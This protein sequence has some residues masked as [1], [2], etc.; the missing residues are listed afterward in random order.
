[1]KLPFTRVPFDGKTA[2]LMTAFAGIVVMGAAVVMGPV[3]NRFSELEGS[4]V[5]SE[6]RMASNLRLSASKDVVESEYR[7]YGGYIAKKGTTSEENAAMLA[8][9]E[10]LAGDCKIVLT[11]T[12]PQES[13]IEPDFEEY[14]ADLEIESDLEQMIRFFFA[15]ESSRQFLRVERLTVDSKGGRE[16]GTL[17]GTL[18][19]SRVVTL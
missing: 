11:K 13:R 7:R 4:I 18:T 16:Q 3:R 8:E 1:V 10:R 15:V 14:K 5:V 19:V 17:K 6:R 2:L 12:T 9:L